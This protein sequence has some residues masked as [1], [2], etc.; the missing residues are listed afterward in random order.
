MDLID[1]ISWK[2]DVNLLHGLFN[3]QEEKLTMSTPLCH[4][5]IEDKLI[6]PFTSS[7]IFTVKSSYNF[8]AKENLDNLTFGNPMHDS[9]IWKLVWG[10]NVPNKVKNFI[11]RSC[12]DD[13]PVKKNLK[14]QQILPND[15]CDH[16][17]QSPGSI[18]HALWE[19]P[20]LEY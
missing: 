17:K 7:G 18:L 3:P 12:R 2:W 5:F 4:T 16:C 11:W 10:L 14:K 8:L 20:E 19:C 15:I 9:G 1:P 13:V 6:W